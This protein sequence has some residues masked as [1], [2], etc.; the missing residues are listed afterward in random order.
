MNMFLRKL[1]SFSLCFL[2]SNILDEKKKEKRQT[3]DI[4]NGQ[5]N[6]KRNKGKQNNIHKYDL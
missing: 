5:K 6:G 1:H 3:N 4:S 2:Y